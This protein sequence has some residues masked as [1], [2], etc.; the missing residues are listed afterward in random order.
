ME[1]Q[2]EAVSEDEAA[3]AGEGRTDDREMAESES[4]LKGQVRENLNE[5]AFFYPRLQTDGNGDVAI[6]FTLP[7]S[8][9]TWNFMALAHTADMMTGLFRDEV[10]AVKEVMAQLNLPRFVRLGDQTVLSASLYN[11]CDRKLKGKVT[12][13]V[14]D[15]KTEK[16]LWR[17]VRKLKMQASADTVLNFVYVPV[18]GYSL[19]ACRVWL[20]G[21]RYT[22]GEQR[23]LPVL[24]N[25][26]WVTETLPFRIKEK[27]THTFDLASLFG[28]N[29]PEA[30]GRRLT[31]EYTGN[32]LWYAVQALP[33]VLTPREGDVG[34]LA[35]AYYASVVTR[36][37]IQR[38]PKLQKTVEQ[39]NLDTPEGLES[40]LKQQEE[41]TGILVDETPWLTEAE[42]E[43]QRMRSLQQLFDENRQQDVQRGLAERL[44]RLQCADGAFGWF[45][46][47]RGNQYMTLKVA[48]YLARAGVLRDK[49]EQEF[50][51]QHVKLDKMMNYLA[52]CYH[53]AVKKHKQQ[54]TAD[55]TDG[56]GVAWLSYLYLAGLSGDAWFDASARADL[57]YGLEQL[58]K[59]MYQL[60]LPD[61]ARAA[62]VWQQTG[63]TREA[64]EMIRSLRE[65]LVTSG[66]G[67]ALEYSSESRYPSERKIA[68]HVA[69]ME[70]L[71]D[72]HDEETM[73]GLCQW[74]LEQKRVQAWATVETSAKAVYALL[75]CQ[76]DLLDVDSRDTVE[77]TLPS[78]KEICQL[79]SGE[80]GPAGL[81]MVKT[82]VEGKELQQGVSTL[83][84]QKNA[85][86]PVS[87][88]AVYAQYRLPLKE[89]KAL[90]SGLRVRNEV[91]DVT[92]KVGDRVM[93]RYVVTSDRDYE[94]VRL[95]VG[96]A[97][98]L[99]P[100]DAR[101]GYER[102]SG[103]G[104][105]KDV[106]DASTSFFFEHLPKGTYIFEVEMYV[107]REGIYT[108][109][110]A[111]LTEVYA[112][113]FAAHSE[114]VV[115]EVKP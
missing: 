79:V 90:S 103:V 37:L 2:E 101:S 8:L 114:A 106:R 35:G 25:K 43:T 32:P 42:N 73:E 77:V 76:G 27:G 15:P 104:F 52:G 81:N 111:E 112:P 65:H 69:I 100:V 83:K 19:L 99:E 109:G 72:K 96:H 68:T 97:A 34:C 92:P 48:T 6:S 86:D 9:T 12:M 46:G 45:N 3:I 11:L 87:W 50:I 53:Q 63:M 98:C 91:S 14:F 62:V 75:K 78:G 22:D 20:D 94:Y 60:S 59:E 54:K 67:I 66:K 107:E 115:L 10:T 40:A 28:K 24:E 64:D 16:V 95:K 102:Q 7:E 84:V 82:Q 18:E 61:K 31:V 51:K 55:K 4:L 74:L 80:S 41:L 21:G 33:S 57:K 113:E 56:F 47:M 49:T 30:E 105:Y 39:W 5:T 17:E 23:Y 88:G 108:L 89:V 13:E 44:G 38:Y 29:H 93:L 71:A 26:E 85:S 70:A 1:V 58:K 110:L 36:Q